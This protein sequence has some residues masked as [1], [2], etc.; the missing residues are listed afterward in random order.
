MVKKINNSRSF[1]GI[2]IKK[3]IWLDPTLNILEKVFLAEIDSL[4][5]EKRGC[6]ST[7]NYF[8]EFFGLKIRRVSD[9][10]GN[11]IK[12]G[13]VESVIN[14][15][16]GN[17]RELRVSQKVAIPY[18]NKLLY[19]IAKKWDRYSKKLLYPYIDE[20]TNTNTNYNI[21]DNKK[22]SLKK[23]LVLD[24]EKAG[25]LA[26]GYELKLHEILPARSRGEKT[27]YNRLREHLIKK[28][29]EMQDGGIFERVLGYAR[30]ANVCGDKP[31]AFFI[32]ACKEKT[33]FAGSAGAGGGMTFGFGL[34]KNRA[35][36]LLKNG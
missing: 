20:N 23:D 8:A 27:T 29:V 14:T 15:A 4:S 2:W 7:N 26:A 21:S 35:L 16:M 22:T 6:F 25:E 19:P 36:D 13:M 11:L 31:R 17:K 3:E 10:I 18:S 28:A 32:A 33:G 1:K 9:V 30:E 5:N 34:K 12:K 24:L